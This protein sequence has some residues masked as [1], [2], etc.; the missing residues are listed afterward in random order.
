MDES[1]LDREITAIH[2]STRTL[3]PAFS[4]VHNALRQKFHWYYAWHLSPFAKIIHITALCFTV[5][6]T[7]AVLTLNFFV[8]P[9]FTL[10]SCTGD[11]CATGDA[12]HPCDPSQ[13]PCT[14][15][16]TIVEGTGQVRLRYG[17]TWNYGALTITQ[18]QNPTF[19]G[20]V[21]SVNS[22]PLSGTE[23]VF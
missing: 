9:P 19:Y 20:I 4:G 5:L 13:G 10:A 12:S 14:C 17:T 23:Q 7:I 21:S 3:I 1:S 6:L 16:D 8:A 18:G 11:G 2:R 15:D 22:M